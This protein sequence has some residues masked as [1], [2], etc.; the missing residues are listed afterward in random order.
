M[1]ELFPSD[2]SE[3]ETAFDHIGIA[4]DR[5]NRKYVR[6]QSSIIEQPVREFIHKYRFDRV[7]IA[8]VRQM[9]DICICAND[10]RIDDCSSAGTCAVVADRC[11]VRWCVGGELY[12]IANYIEVYG[13]KSRQSKICGLVGIIQH[14]GW[15]WDTVK[16]YR[17]NIPTAYIFV[18][19]GVIKPATRAFGDEL[20]IVFAYTDYKLKIAD[21]HIDVCKAL[22][23]LHDLM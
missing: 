17:E 5:G 6:I 22:V 11:A 23:A 13:T 21:D 15:G 4:V 16:M 12:I 7:I 14:Y 19:G 9:S 3:V 8:G 20:G 2:W 1:I 10:V 18:V